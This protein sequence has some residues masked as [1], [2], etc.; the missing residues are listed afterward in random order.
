MEGLLHDLNF[1]VLIS[2]VIFVAL[3]WRP[4]YRIVVTALDQRAEDIRRDIDE[5]VRLREEAQALLA[6][7]KRQQRDAAQETAEILASARTEADRLKEQASAD[8][9]SLL[10]RREQQALD[11]IAQAES[12]AMTEVRGLAVDLA[13]A[14]TR[15]LLAERASGEKAA[16]LVDDSIRQIDA[17]LH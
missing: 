12:Q 8:L 5:A 11:R 6:S 7:Y 16:S 2:F 9:D 4:L 17:K 15:K 10:K 1:W 3:A 14:A 13:I